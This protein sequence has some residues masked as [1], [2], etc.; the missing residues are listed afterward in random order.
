MADEKII[1]IMQP[2]FLP[3]IG[4]WQLI[5]AV[6]VFVIYDNIQYTKKGW[7]N[8]NRYLLNGKDNI[9]TLPLKKD[10]DYLD[11]RDR[12]LFDN[13]NDESKKI[14]RKLEL[15][16]K[17]APYFIETMPLLESCL[18]Q[19]ERNLFKYIFNSIQFVLQH[20]HI[21]TKIIISSHVEIDHSLK[22]KDKVIQICKSLKSNHYINPPG[23]VNL[24]DKNE[25]QREGIDLSF[26]KSKFIEYKQY[27]NEFVPWLSILDVLMF[28]G[29]NKTRGFLHQVEYV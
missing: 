11:I 4:Y 7:I 23:G 1:A 17:Q 15:A 12:F 29:N 10:S 20:L 14:L 22:S 18:I 25:F 6:D 5:N 24:Y 9:F 28:N 26:L 13:F 2:Y 27:N 21:D 3:Y 8:R 19:N 16:Y